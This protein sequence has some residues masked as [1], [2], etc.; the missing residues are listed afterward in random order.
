M[1]HKFLAI[2]QSHKFEVRDPPFFLAPYC[3]DE[4]FERLV[5]WRRE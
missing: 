3:E 5:Q 4:S 2:L 1:V